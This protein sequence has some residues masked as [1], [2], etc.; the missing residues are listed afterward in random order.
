MSHISIH[1]AFESYGYFSPHPRKKKPKYRFLYF[2]H[3]LAITKNVLSH[4]ALIYI[5]KLQLLA[6]K[7]C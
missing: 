5:S 2:Y 7:I 6:Q 4:K 3:L 1:L